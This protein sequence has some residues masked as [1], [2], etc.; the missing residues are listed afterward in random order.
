MTYDHRV[1]GQVIRKLRETSVPSGQESCSPSAL[2]P[3]FDKEP[4]LTKNRKNRHLWRFFQADDQI[5]T[6]DLILTKDALYRLSYIS[7]FLERE[8]Y[9][10]TRALDLQ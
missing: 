7:A 8:N 1:T 6:G 10:T 9:H 2:T 5:R 3:T 4:H